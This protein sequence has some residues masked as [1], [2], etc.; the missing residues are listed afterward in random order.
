MSRV[1]YRH[2]METLRFQCLNA[3]N[4]FEV[5]QNDEIYENKENDCDDH[6]DDYLFRD[7]DELRVKRLRGMLTS[8]P[9]T[10]PYAKK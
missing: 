6:I 3:Q 5:K 4:I 8:Q 2:A 9:K 1:D 7:H 10:V